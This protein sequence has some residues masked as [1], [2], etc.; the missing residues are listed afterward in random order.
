MVSSGVWPPR[1]EDIDPVYKLWRYMGE[2]LS[3]KCMW[4]VNIYEPSN[5][6][7]FRED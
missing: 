4:I 7:Q 2:K 1:E 5:V 6:D 3:H